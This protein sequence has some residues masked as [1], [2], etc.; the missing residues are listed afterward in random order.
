V[1][2]MALAWKD[3]ELG[4]SGWF[5]GNQACFSPKEDLV[6]GKVEQAQRHLKDIN[7]TP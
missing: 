7:T 6:Q 4:K 1:G 3:C 5:Y 2:D